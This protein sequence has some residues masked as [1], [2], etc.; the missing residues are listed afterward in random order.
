MVQ[1][2]ISEPA[3]FFLCL[4]PEK[5]PCVCF[6]V[7]NLETKFRLQ[8]KVDN[9]QI[10]RPALHK[11]RV[12]DDETS[13]HAEWS[14]GLVTGWSRGNLKAVV[15]GIWIMLGDA[16]LITSVKWFVFVVLGNDFSRDFV[17]ENM[18][19]SCPVHFQNGY[20]FCSI[21]LRDSYPILKKWSFSYFQ[22]TRAWK[23]LWCDFLPWVKSLIVYYNNPVAKAVKRFLEQC[24]NPGFGK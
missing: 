17:G 13:D 20:W 4:L 11:L 15:V 10:Y 7:E 16:F 8:D 1:L 2:V 18:W 12:P 22:E 9:L 3:T 23:R 24:Q 21:L 5:T 6:V 19:L 14:Q